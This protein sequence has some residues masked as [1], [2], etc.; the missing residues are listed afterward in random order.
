MPK[1]LQRSQ[2]RCKWKESCPC[3]WLHEGS[4]MCD[5]H[6]MLAFYGPSPV[7]KMYTGWLVVEYF[8][9]VGLD[10]GSSPD[11][12]AATVATY[13]PSRMVEHSKSK[14]TQP[15]YKV[16]NHQSRPVLIHITCILNYEWHMFI[17][18]TFVTL[19]TRTGRSGAS[20]W[21]PSRAAP[22]SS[23]PGVHPQRSQRRRP[24]TN[25]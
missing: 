12:W 23:T 25:W 17:N 13:C 19:S 20:R 9:W 10:L 22:S 6:K 21:W 11:W 16:F 1:L 5:V 24:S 14:S 3:F 15:R 7:H 8:G 4:S 18:R 2:R